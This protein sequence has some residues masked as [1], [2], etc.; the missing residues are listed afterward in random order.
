MVGAR[1]VSGWF[2]MQDNNP[3][4]PEQQDLDPIHEDE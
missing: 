3:A 2:D 1:T 4:D